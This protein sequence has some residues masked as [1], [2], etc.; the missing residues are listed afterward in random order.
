MAR[1]DDDEVSPELTRYRE[2]REL[3]TN[4]VGELSNE[5]D[6]LFKNEPRHI[7]EADADGADKAART[8]KEAIA[9]LREVNEGTL[10]ERYGGDE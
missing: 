7:G 4:L 10:R 1:D 2:A 8:V 3:L 6:K 9:K 5:V